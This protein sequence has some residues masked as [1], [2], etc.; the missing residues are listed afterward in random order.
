MKIARPRGVV[1]FPY[2]KESA[3]LDGRDF[4]VLAATT[5][6]YRRTDPCFLF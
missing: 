2:L 1:M 3:M 6:F 5:W 4:T